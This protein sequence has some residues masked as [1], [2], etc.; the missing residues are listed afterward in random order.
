MYRE[1]LRIG[2]TIADMV[3]NWPA[4]YAGEIIAVDDGSEDGSADAASRAWRRST[5][6]GGAGPGLR[7]VAH[8]RNRGK[9]AAVRTGIAAALDA[10]ADVVLMMDA[11]NATALS[12]APALLERVRDGADLVVGSRAAPGAR[13]RAVPS[14]RLTG[15]VYRAALAVMGLSLARDT[16][17]GFKL[18]TAA[19]GGL[20]TAYGVEDRYA[21][22]VEHLLLAK[23]AGLRTEEVGVAWR[24]V[25]GGTIRPV[26]D[27]LAMLAAS[28]RI[29]RRVRAM[30][31]AVPRAPARGGVRASA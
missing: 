4:G 11:D 2:P 15:L 12:E 6:A 17:C 24:H 10:G 26:R 23:R 22:D 29:A 3:A 25:D 1:A 9:G 28:W 31:V 21:F 16:Q 30:D 19:A 13:V 7:V 20:V 27:G 14:R 8:D 18:Y 5:A